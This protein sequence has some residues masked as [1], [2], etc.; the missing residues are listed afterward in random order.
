MTEDPGEKNIVYRINLFGGHIKLST[1]SVP[2]C[3]LLPS[4]DWCELKKR[5]IIPYPF[6]PPNCPVFMGE[7][8]MPGADNITATDNKVGKERERFTTKLTFWV[9]GFVLYVV[10]ATVISAAQDILSA[11]HFPTTV[12]LIAQIL[13]SATI[14]IICP[15]FIV[16]IRFSLRIAVVFCSL[17]LGLLFISIGWR[18]QWKLFG[19]CMISFGV[20]LGEM[21]ILSL[22]AFYQQ[23]TV[24][25]YAAGTGFGYVCGPLYYTGKTFRFL[26][27]LSPRRLT[28]HVTCCL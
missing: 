20:G 9:F 10:Y 4:T 14:A 1:R 7:C 26:A 22:T 25:A 11:T 6:P 13:P 23:V 18:V 3:F 16:K 19:V 5:D 17:V 15:L 8:S 2:S 21:S 24:G 12:V 27:Q 28:S